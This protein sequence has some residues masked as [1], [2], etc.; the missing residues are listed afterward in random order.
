MTVERYS[1]ID[2]WGFCYL[3]SHAGLLGTSGVVLVHCFCGPESVLV[4]VHK[5][6]PD[7]DDF[8]ESGSWGGRALTNPKAVDLRTDGPSGLHQALPAGTLGS[9]LVPAPDFVRVETR[10]RRNS[11]FK[12]ACRN[13]GEPN[14]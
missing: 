1:S 13:A 2:C 11:T 14:A 8:E 10:H 3:E 7:D 4:R 5:L 9:S 6:V 12:S